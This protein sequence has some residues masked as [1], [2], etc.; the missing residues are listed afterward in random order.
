[1]DKRTVIL[2]RRHCWVR[3]SSEMDWHRESEHAL[4]YEVEVNSN[5]EIPRE[6]WETFLIEGRE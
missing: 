5:P 2:N 3:K 6:T 1:M 4:N